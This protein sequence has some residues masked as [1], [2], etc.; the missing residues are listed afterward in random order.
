MAFIDKFLFQVGDNERIID[1]V[2][3]RRTGLHAM[4]EEI[5]DEPDEG[6]QILEWVTVP[7]PLDQENSEAGVLEV[8]PTVRHSAEGMTLS[9]QGK[10]TTGSVKP[11]ATFT[12][13]GLSESPWRPEPEIE[14]S[15]G[16]SSTSSWESADA[17]VALT[18][19]EYA[20][21]QQPPEGFED[22]RLHPAV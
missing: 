6:D 14:V 9:I 12:F 20:L 17:L 18:V 4:V 5:W 16:E 8:Q 11:F 19:A 21:G 13:Y 7:N 10:T 22:V 1:G 3:S 15:I 2:D